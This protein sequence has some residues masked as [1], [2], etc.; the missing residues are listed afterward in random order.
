MRRF[1]AAIVL[2][3]APLVGTAAR[4][5]SF[6]ASF[7]P[8]YCQRGLMVDRYRDQSGAVDDR[9][10]V[11]TTAQPAGFRAVDGQF[12]YLR[13]RLDASPMQG[14]GLTQ[15]A[16]GF[17]VSTD[18]D[19]TDY[20]ILIVVDGAAETVSLYSNT[21]TTVPDSPADP[22]DQLIMTYPFAQYGRIVDAGASI[23]GGGNDSFL[24]MA[25]PWS[26]LAALGLN[27]TS[28]VSIW[29]A[30]STNPDRLNGDFACHDGGGGAG[31]PSLSGSAPAPIA[32]DPARSP[33]PAGGSGGDSDGGGNVLGSSG[34]EGGPGCN[35]GIGGGGAADSRA[36][37]AL[38]LLGVGVALRL[39]TS[40]SR[41]SSRR[42]RCRSSCHVDSCCT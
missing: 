12:L 33:G 28:V 41:T 21:V 14:N 25:V 31:I 8:L 36:N 29:A 24:D 19:A 18:G 26:D 10:I 23:S 20:E 39:R 40:A 4:G 7:A 35:C 37:I 5:Q 42:R 16:W 30:S 3:L 22:A 1:V 2:V 15:F 34:I 9:D 17:E 38:I 11:G 32:A 27:A 13:L 6:P